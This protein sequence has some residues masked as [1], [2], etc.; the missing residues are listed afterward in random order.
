MAAP[1]IGTTEMALSRLGAERATQT[2]M[3]NNTSKAE[4][5]ETIDAQTAKENKWISAVVAG[6][7]FIHQ[8]S[9]ATL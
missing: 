7:D 4:T 3:K 9:T 8:L 5:I 1:V 2:K 6:S